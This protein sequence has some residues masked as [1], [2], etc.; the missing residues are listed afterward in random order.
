M[1]Q[2][3]LTIS[4]INTKI[5]KLTFD[6]DVQHKQ[7][8]ELLLSMKDR[9]DGIEEKL[10]GYDKIKTELVDIKEKFMQTKSIA[11]CNYIPPPPPFPHSTITSSGEPPPLCVP[12]QLCAGAPPPAPPPPPPPLP[13]LPSLLTIHK[14]N[15][16]SSSNNSQL[17][18]SAKLEKEKKSNLCGSRPVISEDALKQVKLRKVTVSNLIVIYV[19]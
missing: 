3:Q 11:N 5:D 6:L 4:A 1:E 15:I 8:T 19:N 18:K 16:T 14:I 2:Q 13:P 12:S 17:S 7:T 10:N 9:L